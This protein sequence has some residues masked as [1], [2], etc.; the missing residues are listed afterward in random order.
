MKTRVERDSVS[1]PA[2]VTWSMPQAMARVPEAFTTASGVV[3]VMGSVVDSSPD[4]QTSRT[5]GLPE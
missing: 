3:K 1:T 2:V 4:L 5:A